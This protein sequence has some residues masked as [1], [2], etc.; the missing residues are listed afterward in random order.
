MSKA[1]LLQY[2]D[3]NPAIVEELE[4]RYNPKTVLPSLRRSAERVKEQLMIEL[5]DLKA[6]VDG[7]EKYNITVEEIEAGVRDYIGWLK[8]EKKTRK[9][10][11]L[12][13]GRDDVGYW[14]VRYQGLKDGRVH[15][16]NIEQFTFI[17]AYPKSCE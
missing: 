6:L 7:I 12:S 8:R 13:I 15:S 3:E 14:Q 9:V 11:V 2:L 10:K 1:Q 16:D 4:I 5:S 17:G